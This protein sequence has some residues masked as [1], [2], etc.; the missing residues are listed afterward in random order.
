MTELA[1]LTPVEPTAD[2]LRAAFEAQRTAFAR[3]APDYVRR[4]R[5]L[6]DLRDGLRAHE[7]ELI[8]AIT[9]DYGGRAREE[10]LLLELLPL[11]DEI[12]HARRHLRSWISV[13]A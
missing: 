11:Y 12:R 1:T 8:A 3:G 4:M 10:T 7:E 6:A 9:A 2:D 13:G 5:A